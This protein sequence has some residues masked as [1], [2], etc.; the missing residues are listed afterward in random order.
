MSKVFERLLEKQ[1][2][3]FLDTKISTLLCAF[4]KSYISE[5]ALIR[6]TEKIRKTLDSKGVAGMTSKDLSKAFDCIPHD[7][8]IAK[9]NAYGFGAESLRLIANYLS[10]RRQRVK[11]S[12]TYS[13]WLTKKNGTPQGCVLG[14]LMFNISIN[15]FI[16]TIKQLNVCSFVDDNIIFSCGNSFEAVAS[17]L[18]EDMSKLMYWFK[19]KQIVVNAS[20]FQALLFGLNSNENIVL[21]VGGC[22]TDVAN[23]VIL[24]GVTIDCKLK[25]NQHV[26]K[27][28]SISVQLLFLNM[29]V[30]WKSCQ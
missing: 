1:I 3:P 20:K 26:L 25:F 16:Y 8:L 13:I 22:S 12:T 27:I 17:S 29:D 21:E 10:N 23:S 24:L 15:D 19:T 30:L 2:V 6:V 7:L 4:R 11:I 18:E 14:P 5:H 28:C 9:L